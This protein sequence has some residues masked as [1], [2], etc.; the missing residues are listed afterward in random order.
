MLGVADSPS[1]SVSASS[2]EG[3]CAFPG[4]MYTDLSLLPQRGFCC[5]ALCLRLGTA[6]CDC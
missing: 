5:W 2:F 1:L 6:A 3:E 4:L